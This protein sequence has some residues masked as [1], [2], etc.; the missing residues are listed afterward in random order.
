MKK[1]PLPQQNKPNKRTPKKDLE[2][3][4]LLTLTRY[5]QKARSQGFQTVA[6]IDEAGRGP[7]AG[8]VVAAACIIPDGIYFRHINDSKQLTAETRDTLFTELTS[9]PEVLFSVGIID[10]KQIDRVNIYQATILA[11]LQAVEALGLSPDYLLVDGL[12]LPHPSIPCLKIIKGDTLSQ[13]IA[14][15]SIIAKVTR[16]RLMSDYDARWPEYGFKSHK[17]YA[18]P[19]HLEALEKYGPCSLHRMTFAPIKGAN[20]K[21]ESQQLTFDFVGANMIVKKEPCNESKK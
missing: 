16:D 20:Q 17:G 5:E 4:R 10:E 15:A 13:S 6:G 14:A 12:Q 11:M 19:Q 7:L 8:P 9:H 2:I 3:Q 21:N 1:P 18:T